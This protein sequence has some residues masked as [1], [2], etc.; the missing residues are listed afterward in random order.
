MPGAWDLNCVA[1]DSDL[2]S[3]FD[4][5]KLASCGMAYPP[6]L[7]NLIL[8]DCINHSSFC[9]L[10]LFPFRFVG[11]VSDHSLTP[12]IVPSVRTHIRIHTHPLVKLTSYGIR[13][14]GPYLDMLYITSHV[15]LSVSLVSHLPKNTGIV[16]CFAITFCFHV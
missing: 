10:N 3:S 11:Q 15:M 7:A 6:S 1:H 4:F 5:S 2:W 16:L 14:P 9:S 12:Y 8:I 13:D